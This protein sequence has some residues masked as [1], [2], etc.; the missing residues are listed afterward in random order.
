MVRSL[1]NWEL[2]TYEA[3]IGSS[4][5]GCLLEHFNISAS[6]NTK[7]ALSHMSCCLVRGSRQ[8]PS[9][10]EFAV[11]GAKVDDAVSFRFRYSRLD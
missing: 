3:S 8:F 1:T 9:V 4:I 6:A 2:V 5:R 10:G 7:T 11:C